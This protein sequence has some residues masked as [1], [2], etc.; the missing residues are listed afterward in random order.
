MNKIVSVR[1]RR[2]LWTDQEDYSEVQV[3]LLTGETIFVSIPDTSTAC[4]WKKEDISEDIS[5]DLQPTVAPNLY[6]AILGALR[7]ANLR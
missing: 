1:F 4:V 6:R 3:H 5:Y 2:D 7:A